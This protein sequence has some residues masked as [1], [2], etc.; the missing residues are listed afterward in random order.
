MQ[1]IQKFMNEF[2]VLGLLL[3]YFGL[4]LLISL[5]SRGSD[6]NNNAFFLGER[7]S[8]WP[9]VAIGMIG[10]SL[11]GVTFV[12]V[13]G[14]VRDN[15]FL[16]M[17]TVMGFFVGYIL[18]ANVLLPVYYRLNSPSIYVYLKER[19]GKY[20][21]KTGAAF[22]LLSKTIGAAA[23]LYVVAIVLQVFV[24]EK[25][26]VPFALTV[27]LIIAM[28]WM[29]SSRSGIKTIVWT[30][31]LQ[32][33]C[34]LT[35]LVLIILQLSKSLQPE[36]GSVWGLM[37]ASPYMK[38]FEFE[39]WR[40]RQHFVK[41]FFSGIFIALV[42]TGLDQDMMQKNLSI[43]KLDKAKKNIYTYGFAFIPVN[44]L[45]LS[46]GVLLLLFAQKN[47]L[48]LPVSSDDILPV[49]S[50]GPYLSPATGIF[51][52]IGIISAAFSSAD[53]AL[54][55]LTTSFCV[56]ILDRSDDVRI[57]KWVHLLISV[58]FLLII[59]IFKAVNKRSLIDAIYVIAGY[60]YGPLLGLFT[61]GLFSKR[62]VKDKWVP[63]IALS[64][65]V[66]SALFQYISTRYWSY[67]MGYELLMFNGGL[68]LLMLWLS[69]KTVSSQTVGGK[70]VGSKTTDVEGSLRAGFCIKHK[71]R[72]N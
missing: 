65:P 14:M 42:M 66:L 21:Y 49:I 18:I 1:P 47:Q 32:T 53:S 37:K 11:S 45:F 56:D 60:T 51:F 46:L 59:L 29:Y 54:A 43:P 52:I 10:A 4:L 39:D 17:Q 6:Q 68:T 2:L 72:N 34:L 64:A 19:F 70:K 5:L 62:P 28:I 31:L 22:F 26:G 48:E 35:A 63:Y 12:S 20:S 50:T 15:S 61:Y 44:F 55:S 30:D 33:L 36:S 23:R 7:K 41:Q 25:W 24:L 13:P 57:R 40:S 9:V 16:Y 58:L 71:S 3:A 27:I 69:G 38:M 8:P 67:A